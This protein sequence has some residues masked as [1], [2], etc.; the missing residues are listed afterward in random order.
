MKHLKTLALALFALTS[1][2]PM[3][4][5]GTLADVKARV[6][7]VMRKVLDGA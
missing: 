2:A 3:A 4:T 7:M 5:A 6:M 1:L